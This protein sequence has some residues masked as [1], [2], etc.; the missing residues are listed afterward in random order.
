MRIWQF[1]AYLHAP[2]DAAAD[3]IYALQQIFRTWGYESEIGALE[4]A[5]ETASLWQPVAEV[6]P[7]L[8]AQDVVLYHYV[9]GSPLTT[10]LLGMS[11]RLVIYYQNV[12]PAHF[13]APF[14]AELAVTLR[15]GREEIN[16]LR[17]YPALAP[18]EYS[19]QELQG[20]G[21][22]RVEVVPLLV[23]QARLRSS[24]QMPAGA[25]ARQRY[26]DGRDNWL[27]VGRIAPNKR[28][29]DALKSFAYYHHFIRPQSRL[30]FVGGAEH[31]EAYHFN[32][33]R[34]ADHLS[35]ADAVE[36][37]GWV[38][39]TQELGAYYQLASLLVCMSEHEGFCV[40]LLEAMCFDVP[41]LAYAA[42]AVPYTLGDA[43]VLVNE[44]RYDVIAEL[45]EMLIHNAAFRAPVVA[46]QRRRLA[47]FAPAKVEEALRQ[48]LLPLLPA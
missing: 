42:A 47:Q 33:E 8:T 3:F 6:L 36:W 16:L 21:F 29:E 45:A 22:R 15:R 24:A 2:G 13:V 34:L 9:G 30:L 48:A 40:P 20:L 7:T 46:A 23:P 37:C 5:T 35:V 31:F 4:G 26:A 32:L 11:A 39:C 19:R 17:D 25:A 18:S 38:S 12:T 43:G 28:C 41:V 10:Q 14:H 44:K 1:I 27:V